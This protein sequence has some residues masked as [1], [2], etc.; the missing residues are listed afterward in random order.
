MTP[1]ETLCVPVSPFEC[2]TLIN[3]WP[4]LAVILIGRQ[5][6]MEG[7]GAE[8]AQEKS[9]QRYDNCR[10]KTRATHVSD[11]QMVNL[12][13]LE[14]MIIGQKVNTTALVKYYW[15]QARINEQELRQKAMNR[16]WYPRMF[17]GGGQECWC[18]AP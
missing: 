8:T 15:K 4:A 16:T 14:F 13:L 18:N 5:L 7:Q 6:R 11:S 12:A 3:R 17:G 2:A 10:A 9:L 1:P